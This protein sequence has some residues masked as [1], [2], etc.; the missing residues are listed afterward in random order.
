MCFSLEYPRF[1]FV[2]AE[3]YRYFLNKERCET[4]GI[5]SVASW[6]DP[7]PTEPKVSTQNIVASRFAGL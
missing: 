2:L 6:L 7:S 3:K 4:G 5:R 1:C